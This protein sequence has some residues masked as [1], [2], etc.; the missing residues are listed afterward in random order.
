MLLKIRFMLQQHWPQVCT[1]ST[2]LAGT[3][4]DEISGALSYGYG[5][6][7]HPVMSH[8]MYIQVIWNII[9]SKVK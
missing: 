5:F 1:M 6:I 9:G 2:K 8:K 7:Y 4:S 3:L